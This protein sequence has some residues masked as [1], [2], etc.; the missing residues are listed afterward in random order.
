[1]KNSTKKTP[2]RVLAVDVGNTSILCALFKNGVIVKR[3]RVET[4]SVSLKDLR[5]LA[6]AFSLTKGD[7]VVIASVVPHIGRFLALEMRR[8]LG[9]K[10]A[11]IGRDLK[12]PVVN[13]YRDPG[14]VGVDRLMNAVAAYARYRRASI[15]VDFGTAITLD[16]ISRRGEYL[17]GVIAPGIE[18][19]LEALFQKTALLPKTRLAK[20]GNVV[21]KDTVESIRSG[22]AW[23]IGGLVD[24]LVAEIQREEKERFF[25]IVTGGYAKFMR[26]YCRS[27]QKIEPDLTL[28]GIFLTYQRAQAF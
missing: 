22:C 23:G 28:K 21:G 16:V 26:A 10:T 6:A 5:S 3:R 2:K 18:L 8:K 7:Q 14:Q 15:V 25:V 12:A 19:S 27:I 9:L 24:R 11:L 4:R 13:R 20:P 17:G 1:M